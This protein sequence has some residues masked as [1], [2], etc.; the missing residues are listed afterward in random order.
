MKTSDERAFEN[1][2]AKRKTNQCD[3][4]RRGDRKTDVTSAEHR[5]EKNCDRDDR[6]RDEDRHRPSGDA[7]LRILSH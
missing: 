3:R 6:Q 5:P 7:A 2:N 4:A 1:Q